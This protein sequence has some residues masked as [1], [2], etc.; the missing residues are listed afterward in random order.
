[1]NSSIYSRILNSSF[2]T[3]ST[4]W[5]QFTGKNVEK[6]F[7]FFCIP[8]NQE[9]AQ[10]THMHATTV[11]R[12]LS[13]EHN[14]S[15]VFHRNHLHYN[16]SAVI[17]Q[18]GPSLSKKKYIFLSFLGNSREFYEITPMV[19]KIIHVNFFIIIVFFLLNNKH[20]FK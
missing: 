13:T 19:T 3:H 5:Q 17:H 7:L 16:L 12:V 10:S 4:F 18:K 20:F 2:N 1:M 15:A 11:S 8:T 14:K 6:T 9:R